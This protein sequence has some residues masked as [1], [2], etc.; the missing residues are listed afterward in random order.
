MAWEGL[1]EKVVFGLVLVSA[2]AKRRWELNKRDCPRLPRT[3]LKPGGPGQT[4][5]GALGEEGVWRWDWREGSASLIGFY[6]VQEA[7]RN[8][9]WT[10]CEKA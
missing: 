10:P 9:P 4:L 1:S 3:V 7:G 2:E 6:N 5:P 8:V